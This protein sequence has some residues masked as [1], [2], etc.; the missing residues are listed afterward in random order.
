MYS[1][2]FSIFSTNTLLQ[3]ACNLVE[4]NCSDDI[5]CTQTAPELRLL[6]ASKVFVVSW[7]H[8]LHRLGTRSVPTE[9]VHLVVQSRST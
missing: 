4:I 6:T 1:T 8:C 7:T 9:T 5:S 3:I 2:Q